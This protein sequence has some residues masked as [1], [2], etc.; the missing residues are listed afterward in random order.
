MSD[1]TASMIVHPLLVGPIG[2]NCY[3]VGCE[4]TRKAAVIDPGG[5]AERIAECLRS[6]G[7]RLD[8]I[9]DTHGHADHMAANADIKTA[10]PE[11]KIAIHAEDA[12]CL[13]RPALNLS[14]LLGV[15]VK[16]PPADRLLQ[17]GDEVA[18][19]DLRFNV[20]HVPGHTP[21]GIAF[22]AEPDGEPPAVFSGD[23]LFAGGIG[24]T[25]FVRGSHPQLIAAIREKLFTLPPDTRVYPGHG[26]V[27]TIAHEAATNPFLT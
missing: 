6:D 15:P 8:W 7:L 9:L 24:R 14:P 2:T 5:D 10:F 22:C 17:E 1:E 16:S 4:R 18:V 19:G 13:H 12:D 23:A 25:D 26:P 3:V 21:G 11:A 20:L 27:T